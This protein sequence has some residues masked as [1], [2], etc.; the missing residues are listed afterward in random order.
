MSFEK[1]PNF[2]LN[3]FEAEVCSN[4]MP[5]YRFNSFLLD[6]AERRLSRDDVPVSL[7]P[8]AFDVLVYLVER[9]GH[10]VLKDELMQAIWPDS[11]V[12]EVNIP[13]TVHTIR[14]NAGRGR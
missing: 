2:L 4:Q 14:G 11:F 9:G 1:V 12:D 6:V 7:T 13:R 3:F 10:L 5:S 8:K